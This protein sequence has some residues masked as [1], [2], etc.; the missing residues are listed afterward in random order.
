[1]HRTAQRFLVTQFVFDEF[2]LL[3]VIQQWSGTYPVTRF[4]F[5]SGQGNHALALTLRN[6][7]SEQRV[8]WYPGCGAIEAELSPHGSRRDDLETELASLIVKESGRG[9]VRFDHLRDGRHHDDRAFVLAVACYHL[10]QNVG[11]LNFLEV[12][13]PSSDG[14]FLLLD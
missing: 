2:Q 14:G 9:M 4:Q 12:T 1:M 13:P 6:L 5:K 7:I 3:S 8:A 10:L 11:G